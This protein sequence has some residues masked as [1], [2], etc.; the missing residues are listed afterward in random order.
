MQ[1]ASGN[2][3]IGR[4]GEGIHSVR[5]RARKNEEREKERRE[6]EREDCQIMS[7]LCFGYNDPR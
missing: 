7:D 5:R 2:C 1:S 4:K 3:G 6:G